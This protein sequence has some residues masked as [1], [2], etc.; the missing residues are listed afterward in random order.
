MHG[1]CECEGLETLLILSPYIPG[2]LRVY[3]GDDVV[4]S[5]IIDYLVR[6]VHGLDPQPTKQ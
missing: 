6:T 3:T 2:T 1:R 4:T 5:F